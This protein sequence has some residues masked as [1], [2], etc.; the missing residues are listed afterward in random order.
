[1]RDVEVACSHAGAWE[2]EN[3]ANRRETDRDL[4]S[5]LYNEHSMRNSLFTTDLRPTCRAGG[6][7]LAGWGENYHLVGG[8]KTLLMGKY[9]KPAGEF[10]FDFRLVFV[11]GDDISLRRLLQKLL[12]LF[13][14]VAELNRMPGVINYALEEKTICANGRG[15]GTI[16]ANPGQKP[17]GILMPVDPLCGKAE[18]GR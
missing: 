14:V 4:W 5:R 7:A 9:A 16:A 8:H 12:Q 2:Q 13:R 6:V 15:L 3:L 10:A 11:Q 17:L 1:M 18:N